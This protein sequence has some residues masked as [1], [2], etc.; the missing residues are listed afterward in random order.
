MCTDIYIGHRHQSQVVTSL[1]VKLVCD[2]WHYLHDHL[3]M[4]R[5]IQGGVLIYGAHVYGQLCVVGD[6]GAVFFFE[7]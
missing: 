1:W 5:G 3:C 4:V 2:C 6:V 7:I